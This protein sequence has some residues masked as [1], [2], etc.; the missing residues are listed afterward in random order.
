MSWLMP[1][2]HQPYEMYINSVG[3]PMH[4]ADNK[5]CKM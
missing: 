5:M 2:L 1:I 3:D 4:I